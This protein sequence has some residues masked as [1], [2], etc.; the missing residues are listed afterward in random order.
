M[1]WI[2]LGAWAAEPLE[3][4]TIGLGVGTSFRLPEGGVIPVL[5]TFTLRWQV[6]A[7]VAIDPSLVVV[8]SRGHT[9]RP[10]LLLAEGSP[11]PYLDLSLRPRYYLASRGP[12][13]LAGIAGAR[14]ERTSN[15]RDNHEVWLSAELGFALEVTPRP[16]LSI[17]ARATGPLATWHQRRA[18]V[19]DQDGGFSQMRFGS[20]SL[21]PQL[22]RGASLSAFL[23]F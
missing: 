14:L 1:W 20:T 4:R 18:T 5:D 8:A 9:D 3:E 22:G 2:A 17:E 13:H 16:W 6:S 12:V 19:V 10:D 23:F 11:L 21:S 7:R 15:F